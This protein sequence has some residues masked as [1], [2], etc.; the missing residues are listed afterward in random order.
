MAQ[1]PTL[2]YCKNLKI[3]AGVTDYH[4]KLDLNYLSIHSRHLAV[5]VVYLLLLEDNWRHAIRLNQSQNLA[6]GAVAGD[7]SQ[8]KL[9]LYQNTDNINRKW[10]TT[11]K[12]PRM[13]YHQ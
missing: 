11:I 5:L 9:E 4:K 8:L 3:T 1:H 2:A 13:I 10:G 6:V 7:I 12:Y